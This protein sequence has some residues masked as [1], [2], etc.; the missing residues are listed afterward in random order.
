MAQRGENLGKLA[1]R[2]EVHQS[3]HQPT[4][5]LTHGSDIVEEYHTRRKIA[6]PMRGAGL[7]MGFAMTCGLTEFIA[8][9]CECYRFS[10]RVLLG[11]SL[12]FTYDASGN[13]KSMTLDNE[14]LGYMLESRPIVAEQTA[15]PTTP[16]VPP[17][18]N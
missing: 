7:G 4:A 16:G 1:T 3:F 8:F 11:Q 18:A 13:I 9:P 17:T 6:E 2:E 5:I 15:G 12:A 14:P 10:R